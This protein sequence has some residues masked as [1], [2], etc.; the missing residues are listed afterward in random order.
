MS[1]VMSALCDFEAAGTLQP[2]DQAG[3][4]GWAPLVRGVRTIFRRGDDYSILSKAVPGRFQEPAR[5]PFLCRDISD[6]QAG[7]RELFGNL[8]KGEMF[9]GGAI[10]GSVQATLVNGGFVCLEDRRPVADQFVDDVI[11][12][13]WVCRGDFRLCESPACERFFIAIRLPARYCSGRCA[14]RQRVFRF[15][16]KEDS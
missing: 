12:L 10:R 14:T 2:D 6:A 9:S 7:L 4:A 5:G 13:L 15:R 11:S 3:C 8:R 16:S 1:H